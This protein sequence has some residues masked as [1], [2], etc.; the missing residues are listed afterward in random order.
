MLDAYNDTCSVKRLLFEEGGNYAQPWCKG[1]R[2]DVAQGLRKR[3]HLVP[4]IN[5]EDKGHD[6]Q[7]KVKAHLQEED[8]LSIFT[9]QRKAIKRLIVGHVLRS[10]RLRVKPKTETSS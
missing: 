2:N 4:D 7:E 5:W 8:R 10:W 9:V 6:R 1:D 3:H